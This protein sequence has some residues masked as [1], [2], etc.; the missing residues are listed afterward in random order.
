MYG[1]TVC[2]TY[3]DTYSTVKSPVVDVGTSV[4]LSEMRKYN[5]RLLYGSSDRNVAPCC[6]AN[7]DNS[8]Y[9]SGEF[10]FASNTCLPTASATNRNNMFFFAVRRQAS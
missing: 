1:S 8:P 10:N 4:E 6:D 3:A 5:P 7:D 2:D 9:E